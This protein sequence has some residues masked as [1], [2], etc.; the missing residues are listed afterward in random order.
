MLG[1]EEGVFVAASA[2][3]KA[4]PLSIAQWIP[5]RFAALGTDGFG[6]SESRPDLRDHFE[7]SAEHIVYTTI[8]VLVD[9]GKCTEKDLDAVTAKLEINRNKLDAAT[10]GPAQIQATMKDQVRPK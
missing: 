5:G 6:V 10:S 3:M 7:V 4:Q 9:E 8:A 1:D 2:Y